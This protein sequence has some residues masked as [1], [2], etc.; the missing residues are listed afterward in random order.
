MVT[1][2]ITTGTSSSTFSPDDTVS[3]GQLA[4]FFYRYKGSPPVTVDPNHP[5]IPVC[6]AQVPGP[7]TTGDL[8]IDKDTTLIQNHNGHITIGTDN[9]TLDCAGHTITGHGAP[10]DGSGGSGIGIFERTGVTVKNCHV[11]NFSIGFAL[12]DTSGNKLD[13]N[14]ATGNNTNFDLSGAD[15]NTL[16]N[17]VAEGPG[18]G[19]ALGDDNFDNTLANNTAIGTPGTS[20]WGNSVG[21]TVHGGPDNLSSGNVFTGNTATGTARGI[22]DVTSGSGTAGTNNTYAQNTC[23]GNSSVASQPAGLC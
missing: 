12:G 21:F 10:L 1:E 9:V 14:R 13:S 16:S 8:L 15:N 23:I 20:N 3:R 19:F 7:A 18:A 17:N 4:A 2:A 6:A 22:V 5:A 11:T